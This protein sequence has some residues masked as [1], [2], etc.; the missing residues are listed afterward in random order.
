[1]GSCF[2]CT[3]N[4]FPQ[5]TKI[6]PVSQSKSEKVKQAPYLSTLYMEKNIGSPSHLI[7]SIDIDKDADID[8]VYTKMG[9]N[10]ILYSQP[11]VM[12]HIQLVVEVM[13]DQPIRS[14]I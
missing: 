7:S 5:D 6:H 8:L 4:T 12:E 13:S 10:T 14:R 2:H 9:I 1:M 3:P 11:I